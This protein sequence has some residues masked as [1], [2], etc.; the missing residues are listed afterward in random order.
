[1]PWADSCGWKSGPGR[2]LRQHPRWIGPFCFPRAGLDPGRFVATTPESIPPMSSDARLAWTGT[3]ADNRMEQVRVEAASWQNRPVFFE[4]QLSAG[5]A[6]ACVD[7]ESDR[8]RGDPEPAAHAADRWRCHGLEKSAARP[9]RPPRRRRHGGRRLHPGAGAWALGAGHAASTLEGTVLIAMV[10]VP[11]FV[12]VSFWLVYVALEPYLRRNWPDALVSWTRLCH[13]HIRDPVVAS[14]ILVGDRRGRGVWSDRAPGLHDIQRRVFGG[15][16]GGN[17]VRVPAGA[18]AADVGVRAGL[19]AGGRTAAAVHSQTAAGGPRCWPCCLPSLPDS[20]RTEMVLSGCSCRA[21]CSVPRP[22]S[23][24]GC[25][26][27]LVF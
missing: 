26:A 15:A 27:G 7:I 9:D 13:G 10:S 22:W 12:A 20:N 21:V 2:P 24:C 1:M 6:G 4:I 23:G 19:R 8:G 11:V 5:A 3:Y 18:D 14:H 25:F 16:T 17:R